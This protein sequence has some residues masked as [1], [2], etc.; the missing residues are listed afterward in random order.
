LLWKFNFKMD[1]QGKPWKEQK[2]KMPQ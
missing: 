1:K 2:G